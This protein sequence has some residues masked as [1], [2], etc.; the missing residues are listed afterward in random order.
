KEITRLMEENKILDER[1]DFMPF[2]GCQ[3]NK[4]DEYST[5]SCGEDEDN[6][7]FISRF[8]KSVSDDKRCIDRTDVQQANK[9]RER[10]NA[11]NLDDNKN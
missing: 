11:S 1:K 7:A 5:I 4:P 3:Y 6:Y 9:R 10:K 8:Y 2:F